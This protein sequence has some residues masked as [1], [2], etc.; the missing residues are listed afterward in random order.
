MQGRNEGRITKE[1]QRQR[2]EGGEMRAVQTSRQKS[3][4]NKGQM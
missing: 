1:T 4:G 3:K 2:K